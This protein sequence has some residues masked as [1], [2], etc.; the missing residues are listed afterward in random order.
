MPDT[1]TWGNEP[2]RIGLWVGGSVSPNWYDKAAEQ[3]TEVRDSP[4][5]ARTGVLQTLVCPWCGTK[6]A[7]HR[8]LRPDDDRRRIL[9]YC[10]SGEGPDPCPFSEMRSRGRGTADPDRRRGDL[11]AAAQPGRRDRGQARAASLAR[12]RGH[13]VRP[14]QP[15]VPAARLPARRHGRAHRLRQRHNE[16]EDRPAAGDQPARHQAAPAGPD[17]P[18]RAAPDLRRARHHRRPVR[19]RRRRTLRLAL[20][21]VRTGRVGPKIVAS[22]AT[23]KRAREQARG[24]F[25][26][27]LAVFPPPALDITDTFFSRQVPVTADTPGRRY[28]GICA[29]GVRLKSAEIRLA[30]ILLIAGQTLFDTYGDGGRPVHDRGGL[31]QRHPRAGRHAPL[32]R[33][34]R[35]HPGPAARPC[36]RACPTGSSPRPACS[37]SRS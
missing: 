20:R 10:P 24:L 26:R 17:H 36:P 6:L 23:T 25:G 7:A 35:C 16:V 3:I 1:K 9:L 30:E 34:R 18:G 5:S 22:T 14:G 13:A 32:P 8:D 21:G 31:L 28:L 33:R 11:P 27:D 19:G 2:F 29:H 12:V 4:S 15:A 37:P